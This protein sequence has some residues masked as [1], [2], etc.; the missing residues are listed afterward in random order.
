MI[1]QRIKTINDSKISDAEKLINMAE[2]RK[3]T[4]CKDDC[5]QCEKI[6]Q[7]VYKDKEKTEAAKTMMSKSC[8][9]KKEMALY[10]KNFPDNKC[11]NLTTDEIASAQNMMLYNH[12]EPQTTLPPTTTTP[13]DNQTNEQRSKRSILTDQLNAI[14]FGRQY[15]EITHCSCSGDGC[16]DGSNQKPTFYLFIFLLSFSGFCQGNNLL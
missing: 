15:I 1:D 7:T 11:R 13:N 9:G 2:K 16:N 6:I 3:E 10:G 8:V 14:T 5:M 4:L 12:T